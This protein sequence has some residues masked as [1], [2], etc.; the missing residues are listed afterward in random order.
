MALSY[1]DINT[2]YNHDLN[3]QINDYEKSFVT[4]KSL[5]FNNINDQRQKT[6]D[7]NEI[8]YYYPMVTAQGKIADKL[9]YNT[10]NIS[11]TSIK[12]LQNR[13]VNDYYRLSD[14]DTFFSS[15]DSADN[16]SFDL[17]KMHSEQDAESSVSS[18][19]K[20]C[21]INKKKHQSKPIKFRSESTNLT[22]PIEIPQQNNVQFNANQILSLLKMNQQ[23]NTKNI[24]QYFDFNKIKELFLMVLI[25]T[26]IILILDCFL[27]KKS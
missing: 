4:N 7:G 21:K 22:K 6:L 12:D 15:A 1:C 10:N 18:K 19:C 25:G 27:R 8:S 24:T 2:A 20:H 17:S 13:A 3:K 9:N 16:S 5:F 14:N 26:I 23:E 11:G